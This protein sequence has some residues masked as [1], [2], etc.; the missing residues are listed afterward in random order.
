MIIKAKI[1]FYQKQLN[2]VM[3]YSLGLKITSTCF[4][5]SSGGASP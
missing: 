2:A 5:T 1:K 3:N 4:Y